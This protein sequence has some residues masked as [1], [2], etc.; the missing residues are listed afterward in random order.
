[1][2][3]RY[4]R[5]KAAGAAECSPQADPEEQQGVK[6]AAQGHRRLAWVS[7]ARFLE[8]EV[9][10]QPVPTVWRGIQEARLYGAALAAR[11]VQVGITPPYPSAEVGAFLGGREARAVQGVFRRQEGGQGRQEGR[12][13]VVGA[14]PAARQ[15]PWAP[16]STA[17]RAGRARCE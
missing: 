4:F 1:M 3:E 10:G 9:A 16:G 12:M 11:R 5:R 8:E 14:A 15:V 13:V 7:R 2:L 6:E 17:V